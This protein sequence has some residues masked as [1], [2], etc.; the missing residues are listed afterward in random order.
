MNL[1]RFRKQSLRR[2]LKKGRRKSA[3]RKKRNLEKYAAN[4]GF[5][6]G[7]GYPQYVSFT[8][9]YKGHTIRDRL[10]IEIDIYLT[11]CM[12]K[13]APVQADGNVLSKTAWVGFNL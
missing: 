4:T 6:K 10:S 11:R 5:L 1:M 7:Q 8:C 2:L 12:M 13:H 9:I 3:R